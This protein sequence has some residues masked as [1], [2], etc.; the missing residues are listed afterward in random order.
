MKTTENEKKTAEYGLSFTVNDIAFIPMD[1]IYLS[2]TFGYI[3]VEGLA[4]DINGVIEFLNEE[5]LTFVP[6]EE[7]FNS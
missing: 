7:E 1:D 2:P 3:R 4:S 6:T 5:M